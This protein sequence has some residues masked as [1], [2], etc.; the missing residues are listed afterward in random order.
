MKIRPYLAGVAALAGAILIAACTSEAPP[1]QP[2]QSAPASTPPPASMASSTARV[3]F[4][5]PA[6]GATVKSPVHMKFGSEGVTI[7]PVPPDPV[8]SVRPGTGHYHLG[9]EADCLAPAME[10]VKGTPQ[11]VHFGKGDDQFD[12]QLTP[13]PHKLS[14]QIGDDKHVTMPGLCSTIT[15]NVAP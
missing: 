9:V 12:L 2:A 7:S 11:W 14:L 13:G 10:I 3:F 4:V 1:A 15:L 8:T 6:N 5:E